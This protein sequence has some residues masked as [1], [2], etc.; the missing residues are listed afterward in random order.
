M[1][2]NRI[3]STSKGRAEDFLESFARIEVAVRKI[4]DCR[5]GRPFGAQLAS[6]VEN[7]ALIRTLE[8]ELRKLASLRNAIVHE[9]DRVYPIAGPHESTVERI[10]EIAELLER[11]PVVE[12]LLP[13]AVMRCRPEDPVGTAVKSMFGNDFSQMPV[14]E[15]GGNR[16]VGT[17]TAEA[18]A[19][20]VSASLKRGGGLMEDEPVRS[21]LEYCPQDS[22]TS[23]VARTASILDLIE[24]FDSVTHEGNTLD[25]VL[26]PQTGGE[27]EV[28]LGILTVYDLPKLFR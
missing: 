16:F 23:F 12:E 21:A 14:Y 22:R 15:P 6:A 27:D 17:L 5:R 25:A 7:D 26:I 19:R 3:E 28:P 2:V 1:N 20:W 4:S 24:L 11:P 10:E 13:M 9:R 8:N 18:V